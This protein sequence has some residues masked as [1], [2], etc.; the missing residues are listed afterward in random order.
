VNCHVD[1][2]VF[3]SLGYVLERVLGGCH[4]LEGWR[5]K[6]VRARSTIEVDSRES[7]IGEEWPSSLTCFA[8]RIL[9]AHSCD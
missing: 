4:C 5:K 6:R 8:I 2:T 3:V 9:E 1:R 7:K